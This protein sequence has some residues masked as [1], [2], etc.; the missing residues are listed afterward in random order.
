ME[1]HQIRYFLAVAETLNFTRAAEE[2]HVAQPSLSRAIQKLEEE[3]GGDLFRRERGRTHL[4][5]LGRGMHPLLRQAFDSA[6]AAKEQAANFGSASHAPLRIGLSRTVQLGLIAPMLGELAKAYP[7][8]EL[9][10][11]REAAGEILKLLEA[12]EIEL[13]IAAESQAIWD[14]LDHWRLFEEEFML[15]APPDWRQSPVAFASLDEVSI[16]ARPYCETLAL[17]RATRGAAD[18]D[19]LYRHEVS[20]DEDAASL[21]AG[22][23]GVAIMPES[24]A[25]LLAGSVLAIDGFEQFREV[26]VYGVAGRRRSPGASGLL[27]LLRAADWSAVA[28]A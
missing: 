6:N 22:G 15:L 19:P 26:R 4:T 12:G 28:V 25:R 8:L 10:F 14:R 23:L 18:E 13:A 17:R 24:S 11:A 9:H 7:G 16:I 20:S 3:L 2:C 21:V 27:N 5:E 1:M